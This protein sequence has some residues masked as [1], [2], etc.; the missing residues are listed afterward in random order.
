MNFAHWIVQ[1][2]LG[3]HGKFLM[4]ERIPRN[5][6]DLVCLMQNLKKLTTSLRI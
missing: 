5:F 3:I 6:Q 4:F 1:I 2:S